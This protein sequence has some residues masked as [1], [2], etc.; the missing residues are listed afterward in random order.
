MRQQRMVFTARKRGKAMRCS[1]V[2][3]F[4]GGVIGAI[5]WAAAM[6]AAPRVSQAQEEQRLPLL[7]DRLHETRTA[8]SLYRTD[9]EGLWPG[10]AQAGEA[11]SGEAFAAALTGMRKDGSGLY[12]ERIPENPF[13]RERSRRDAV[14]TGADTRAAGWRFDAATGRFVA[15]DSAFHAQY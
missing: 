8:I 11:V 5:L 10:Q 2:K 12:L 14:V 13:V 4:E 15:W 1:W 6:A 9:H 3:V 7:I